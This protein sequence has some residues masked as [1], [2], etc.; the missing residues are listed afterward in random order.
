MSPKLAFSQ[1]ECRNRSVSISP[2]FKAHNNKVQL[3]KKQWYL[4]VVSS[5]ASAIQH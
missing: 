5:A 4:C 1:D 2:V 3:M